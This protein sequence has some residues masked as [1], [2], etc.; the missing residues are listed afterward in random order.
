MELSNW[1][2]QKAKKVTSTFFFITLWIISVQRKVK[3]KKMVAFKFLKNFTDSLVNIS[4]CQTQ[5]Q[6]VKVYKSLFA[7][8]KQPFDSKKF[9]SNTLEDQTKIEYYNDNDICDG[10]IKSVVPENLVSR[11]KVFIHSSFITY[12]NHEKPLLWGLFFLAHR[13]E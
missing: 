5:S 9:V 8:V 13:N 7:D 12:S 10:V 1:M 6:W 2:F 11:V 4:K 3:P